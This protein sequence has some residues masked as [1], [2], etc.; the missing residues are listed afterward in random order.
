MKLPKYIN[1]K[2]VLY[3]TLVLAIVNVLCILSVQDFDSLTLFVISGLLSSYFSKNMIINLTIAM[4]VAN[5]GLVKNVFREGMENKKKKCFKKNKK[6]KWGEV[7][8]D[9]DDCTGKAMCWAEKQDMCGKGKKESMGQ[10]N[11]P[12]SKPANLN[13]DDD[14]TE[15]DRVDYASTLESAYDNLQNMLGSDGVKGLT[16]ETKRLVDQQK[17]L[18]E[19]LNNMA[20]VLNSAKSTLDGLK[21]PDIQGLQ[22]MMTKINGK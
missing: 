4:L 13:D 10:R 12:S 3:L 21:L 22:K 6:G 20:P 9:E 2:Y 8:E 18:M 1:N 5:T 15:V 7:D 17:S 19:S 11:V 14:E 16:S